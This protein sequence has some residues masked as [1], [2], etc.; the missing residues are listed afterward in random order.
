[1]PRMTGIQVIEKMRDCY[2]GINKQ[3]GVKVQEPLYVFLTAFSNRNFDI[4]LRQL[5][6]NDIY[7]KPLVNEQL[8]EILSKVVSLI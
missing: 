6:I 1:M 5:G 3:G 7:E 2:K 8:S 4:H